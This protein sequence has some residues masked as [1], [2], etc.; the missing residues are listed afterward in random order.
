MYYITYYT[1]FK[2][3]THVLNSSAYK[4]TH[5]FGKHTHT[6]KRIAYHNNNTYYYRRANAQGDR[7]ISWKRKRT[8][9]KPYDFPAIFVT[10]SFDRS[11][12]RII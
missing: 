3:G 6:C 8:V 1:L 7:I 11:V 5:M 4:K 2:S 9:R 10:L 12:I